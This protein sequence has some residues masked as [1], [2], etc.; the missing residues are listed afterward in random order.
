[1]EPRPENDLSLMSPTQERTR[2]SESV[3][4]RGRTIYEEGLKASLEP[5]Q[6]GRFVAIEPDSGRYFLGDNGADALVAAHQAMP[7][8]EFYLK[9]IG[10][11]TTYKLGGRTERHC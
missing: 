6:K 9:R 11:D 7:G 5:E 8:S 1:M 10:F 2:V 3:S 4:T